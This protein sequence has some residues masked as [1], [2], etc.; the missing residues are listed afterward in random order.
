M[1][2]NLLSNN[3]YMR[4]FWQILYYL[5]WI[6]FICAGILWFA[7]YKD[8]VYVWNGESGRPISCEQWAIDFK[9]IP[10]LHINLWDD[11][12]CKID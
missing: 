11:R 8:T 5:F 2:Y 12:N 3:K 4:V 10:I 6:L 7:V 9:I 1:I